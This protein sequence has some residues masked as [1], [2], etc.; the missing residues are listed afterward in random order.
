[1]RSKALG[2]LIV[3]GVCSLAACGG[4]GD[5]EVSVDTTAQERPTDETTPTSESEAGL[6]SAI[7]DAEQAVVQ[8]VARGTFAEPAG[9]LA[10]YEEVIG[11]GS[12]S[13]FIIDPAGIAVTNNH[14]VTGAATLDV[15]VGGAEEPLSARVL[16]V[17]ECADLAVIDIDGEGYS[18]LEWYAGPIEP[19][20][21]VRAAG[22]PVG[23]P[24]YTLTQGI[25]SKADA[26]G[27]SSWSSVD[28][29]IEHDAA[30]QPG[31]SGGP[32]LDAETAQVVAVNYAS[33]DP[34]TGTNQFFAISSEQAA[35]IVEQLR[36]GEDVLSLGINGQA[37]L[38]DAEGVAG[39]WVSSVASGTPASEL[40]LTGGDIV[41]RIEGL[42]VGVDG[43]MKDYCDILQSHDPT[44]VLSTQ[45]LRFAEGARFAGAF[46]G[47][48]LTPFE[49]LPEE[50]ASELPPGEPYTEYTPVTDDSGT[51][52]ISVPVQWSE[53]NGAPVVAD[54]GTEVRDVIAA[55][56]L[57]AFVN[58]WSSSGVDFMVIG[59]EQ[60]LTI[61]ELLDGI[62][63][64]CTDNG[65]EPY[66]DGLYV[67]EV[68]YWTACDGTAAEVVVIAA[69]PEGKEFIV[70]VIAQLA[71]QA[72]LE[73]LDQIVQTFRVTV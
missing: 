26:D 34:G 11:A 61:T 33:D 24:E 19:N 39:I 51:L 45:V 72:D 4:G 14:V 68:Q 67:G 29:V 1:M 58:T 62:Q 54:D 21:E 17:S 18:F 38:D 57:N 48:E 53:V 44:D 9:S 56:D 13:G 30:I 66:D 70:R 5:D 55:P 36:Q 50:V 42:P 27:E 16:G 60:A 32:L 23:D 59:P 52:E 22:F 8:I 25:V 43:T 2:A 7:A 28:S 65:R 20:L 46:N 47:D 71:T 63:P 69:E 73:A 35:P 6:V 12:G 3:A 40:G 41:E 49:T 31:N 10:A 64:T 37:V 15:F